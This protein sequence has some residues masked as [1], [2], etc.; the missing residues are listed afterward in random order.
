V[1]LTGAA[2][3]FPLLALLLLVLLVV[4]AATAAGWIGRRGIALSRWMRSRVAFS[5]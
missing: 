1:T 5:R 4:G 3:F 2:L